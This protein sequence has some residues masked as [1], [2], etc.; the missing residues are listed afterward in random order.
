MMVAVIKPG[1]LTT[2]Q[3]GG[4]HGHAG[5]GVGRS[6]AMD[7]PA[8][9]LANALVGNAP[10][11]AALEITLLGP[12]LRFQR[13]AVIAITGAEI[14]AHVDAAALP[15]WRP[16]YMPAGSVLKLGGMRRGARCYLAFAGGLQASSCLGSASVDVNAGIGRALHAGADLHIAEHALPQWV[17]DEQRWHWPSWSLAPA[18]WFEVRSRPLRAVT[19]AHFDALDADSR[20]AVFAEEFRVAADSNRVGFRLQGPSLKLGRPL[21][22]ISEAVDFGTVQL[23]P[24]GAAV[25]LMAEHPTTGGYPRIVQVAAADLSYLAQHRPGDRL[26]FERIAAAHAERLL[27]EQQ[28]ALEELVAEIGRRLA[29]SA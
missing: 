25:V 20:S 5:L 17:G 4:R 2:V 3:D 18:H 1:M 7:R 10:A 11:A 28:R 8:L 16:L 29:T 22:L 23:P 19:G 9:C 6:G 21:E 14:D 26:R 24:G 13:A 27:I 15:M 12:V